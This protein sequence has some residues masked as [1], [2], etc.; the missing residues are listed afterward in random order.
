MQQHLSRTLLLLLSAGLFQ[1]CGDD[2][3]TTD[4]DS[5][6]GPE[7]MGSMDGGP[8]DGGPVDEEAP[9]VIGTDPVD[10]AESVVPRPVLVFFSESMDTSMGELTLTADDTT[11]ATTTAWNVDDD[12]LTIE[13]DIPVESSIV[14]TLDGFQDVAGNVLPTYTFSFSTADVTAPHVVSSTPEEGATAVAPE[15]TDIRIDVSETLATDS[16]AVTLVGG[17][18]AVDSWTLTESAILVTVSG[19]VRETDYELVLTGFAD[20]AGNALDGER[21]LGDGAL[22]FSTGLDSTAPMVTSSNPP[23][24][25]VDVTIGLNSVSVTFSEPMDTSV[26][27]GVLV[28]GTDSRSLT[29]SWRDG[30]TVAR[31]ILSDLLLVDTDYAMTLVGFVDAAGNALDRT[32]YLVD[33]AVDFT[34]GDDIFA[35]YV[36]GSSPLEAAT[37]V[38]FDTDF[39]QV[40]FSEVMDTSITTA[41]VVSGRGTVAVDGTWLPSGTSIIFPV[42]DV[43]IAGQSYTIDFSGF[44]DTNGTAVDTAHFY[45]GD[46]V[47]QFDT[48]TPTGERCRDELSIAEATEISPGVHRWDIADNSMETIDG[49]MSCDTETSPDAVIRFTK[50]SDTSVLRIEGVGADPMAMQVLEGLCDSRDPSVDSQRRRCVYN[51]E[52]M[53]TNIEGPAGDYYI[54]VAQV[55]GN[56]DATS[57]TIEEIPVAPEGELCGAPLVVGSSRYYTAP[58]AAG[59]FHEWTVPMDGVYG[60]D[61]GV[62][63]DGPADFPCAAGT[64]NDRGAD[65]VI[66]VDKTTSSSILELEIESTG[67]TYEILDGACEPASAESLGCA[68]DASTTE[69]RFIIGD[70]R[71][72][73]I[74][75]AGSTHGV[76]DGSITVRAREVEPGPG[77]SCGTALPLVAGSNSVT[78]TGALSIDA[79]ACTSSGLTW[80]R[81]TAT[82]GVTNVTVDGFV[83]VSI[84]DPDDLTSSVRCEADPTAGIPAFTQPGKEYCLAVTSDP[85]VT[86]IDL[87]EIDYQGVI[88][89]PVDEIPYSGL[90]GSD[91][92]LRPQFM[93]VTPTWI[94][95]GVDSADLIRIPRA[96]GAAEELTLTSS[97]LGD[98]GLA[99]GE[100]VFT[101][102]DNSDTDTTTPRLWRVVDETGTENPQPWDTGTTTWDADEEARAIS[103][104][105]TDIL[106]ASWASRFTTGEYTDFWAAD[107]SAAGPLTYLGENQNINDVSGMAADAT[108]LYLIGFVSGTEGVFRLRRDQLGDPMAPL[109]EIPVGGLTLDHS[110]QNAH[111]FVQEVATGPDILYFREYDFGHIF[112]VLEPGGASPLFLGAITTIGGTNVDVAFALDPSV[113]EYFFGSDE[114]SDANKIYRAR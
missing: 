13:A 97:N 40:A 41:E 43:V 6:A 5:D 113:P 83:P 19:L 86:S 3:R 26:G 47:L 84:V 114:G 20:A 24:G 100:Q 88:G 61:R 94:Y 59:E 35:P 68:F 85:G 55:T 73:Y 18:G 65:A 22:D 74:W 99:I 15:L 37:D 77:D 21:Y 39:V 106:I 79:P 4:S 54:W 46:G 9:N 111:I 57:V 70:A 80:Y 109:E 16:G 103:Y 60:F 90:T 10:G 108:Y 28:G 71:P 75:A 48:V 63:E 23:E 102:D 52:E 42:A 78:P 32:T 101:L 89:S 12:Q 45:L 36:V 67:A 38:P 49:S 92:L 50:T 27:S 93:A 58:S 25:A 87:A 95:I 96:G 8:G 76:F 51:S 64:S 69:T 62:E 53:G 2:D 104:D 105:G 110:Y 14:V 98:D 7:D 30:D 33:G 44:V 11:L 66:R 112:A 56:F 82:T 72:F 34:T 1:A 81:F 17:P 31:F 29:P 107:P 91:P